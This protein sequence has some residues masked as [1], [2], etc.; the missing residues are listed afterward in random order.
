MISST[1]VRSRLHL[2]RSLS[3][4]STHSLPKQSHP[5]FLLPLSCANYSSQLFAA[6]VPLSSKLFRKY[7]YSCTFL[8]PVIH[9]FL[10][11][12]STIFR[13]AHFQKLHQ[14]CTFSTVSFSSPHR[15]V[16]RRN[17]L[18]VPRSVQ[19]VLS[20]ASFFPTLAHSST[21]KHTQP[22]RMLLSIHIQLSAKNSEASKGLISTLVFSLH[23]AS[24]RKSHGHVAS[25]SLSS[26]S[27]R[28]LQD[29]KAAQC[30]STIAV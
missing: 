21:L 4:R 25:V 18:C 23:R 2:A 12:P 7:L 11:V 10:P 20:K 8:S 6:T 9:D 17:S 28:S 30:S 14:R 15:K 5:T 26:E 3:A 19:P 29:L 13:S 22:L 16:C 1:T 27:H 24:F